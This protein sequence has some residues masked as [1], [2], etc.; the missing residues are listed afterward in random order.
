MD[1]KICSKLTIR[2]RDPCGRSTAG[3]W[4]LDTAHSSDLRVKMSGVDL[5]RGCFRLNR[6]RCSRAR[7]LWRWACP[8][9]RM[10]SSHSTPA[11]FVNAPISNRGSA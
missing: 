2:A 7:K 3:R 4:S 10:T 9:D 6:S 8:F 5:L 1:S 11:H